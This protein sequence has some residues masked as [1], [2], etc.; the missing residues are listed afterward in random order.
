[1]LHVISRLYPAIFEFAW[2]LQ[3]TNAVAPMLNSHLCSKL[4][5]W[6]MV[7]VMVFLRSAGSQQ[8]NSPALGFFAEWA[9]MC[10]CLSCAKLADILGPED[11]TAA[12]AQGEVGAAVLTVL[13]LQYQR[14]VTASSIMCHAYSSMIKCM[15]C[16]GTCVHAEAKLAKILVPEDLAASDAP[17]WVGAP[18]S[19]VLA[20]QHR[21]EA[22]LQQTALQLQKLLMQ[23]HRLEALRY[24]LNQ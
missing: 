13:G 19:S 17:G 16:H 12:D 6:T 11:L 22:A 3:H 2:F 5:S 7:Q 9:C 10:W 23:G 18:V 24:S 21:T 4:A 14:E 8:G 20:P 15:F 1:M